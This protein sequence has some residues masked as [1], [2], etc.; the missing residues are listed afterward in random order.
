MESLF[1]HSSLAVLWLPAAV[2][3]SLSVVVGRWVAL[4]RMSRRRWAAL[5]PVFSTWEVSMG[6]S[7]SR[8]LS[9]LA[10]TAGASELLSVLLGL[11]RY[12]ATEWPANV[13]LVFWFVIQLAVSERLARVFGSGAGLAA[14]LVILP[15][16]AY[17]LLVAGDRVYLGPN[18]GSRS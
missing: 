5:V 11:G 18:G 17:P 2:I 14:D 7:G 1:V 3:L 13:I 16:V 15:V 6:A 8:M 4:G 12:L 9:A 10:A